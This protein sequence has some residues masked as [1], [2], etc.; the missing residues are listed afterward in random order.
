MAS[1][2]PPLQGFERLILRQVPKTCNLGLK[3]A[4]NTEQWVRN[5]TI[6]RDLQIPTPN[7]GEEL[8]G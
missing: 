3:R 2:Q 4:S 6:R 7:K 1:Y 8:Q 5:G